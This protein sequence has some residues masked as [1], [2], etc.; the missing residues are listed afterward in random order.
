[1]IFVN[2]TSYQGRSV[3]I[4]NGKVVIDGKDVTPSEK[5]IRIRYPQLYKNEST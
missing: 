4:T 5:E 3:V 1:M 2:N